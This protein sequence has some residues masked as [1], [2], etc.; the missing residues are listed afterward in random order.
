M[1]GRREVLAGLDART[2]RIYQP[3]WDDLGQVERRLRE[4][5]VSSPDDIRDLLQY[6]LGDR[7]KRIRPAITLLTSHLH[8]C[9]PDLPV[10]I[11]TAIELLHL[12]TLI[13]DDTVD[14][15]VMRRGRT[16]VSR[17]WDSSIAVLLGDYV[18]GVS[19]VFVSD[20][21]NVRV[22]R[23]CA[24][25]VRDLSH[26]QLLEHLNSFNWQQTRKEYQARIFYK[27]A[28]LFRTA[29]QVGTSLSGAPEEWVKA[30]TSYGYNL[31][32]AFQVVDDILDY[33]GDPQEVG[34]P[35]GND[36][37]Q[38]VV[39]LPAIILMERHPDAGPVKELFSSKAPEKHLPQLTGLIRNAGILDEC[40]AVAEEFCDKAVRS[41]DMLPD[42]PPR[43]S[44]IELTRYVLERRR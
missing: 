14:G 24:E 3:V 10:L 5:L 30:L 12:A 2:R 39:T 23:A 31:G 44:L 34:K 11:A 13:H 37:L 1:P 9:E 7:G 20:T 27:T 15:S 32:M 33:E 28:S 42:T 19:S 41:L 29:A 21:R 35:V 25:T 26:G 4:L 36:L 8:P 40:R 22:I 16:T 17:R 43:S 6:V 18:F 38:G